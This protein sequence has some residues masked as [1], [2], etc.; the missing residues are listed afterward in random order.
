MP[1]GP[2]VLSTNSGGGGGDLA[3]DHIETLIM[4]ALHGTIGRGAL[5]WVGL[6]GGEVGWDLELEADGFGWI[7]GEEVYCVGCWRGG[8]GGA[9]QGGVGGST[10]GGVEGCF[11][12]VGD[13]AVGVVGSEVRLV[14]LDRG[15]ARCAIFGDD[16]VVHVGDR[17]LRVVRGFIGGWG[18]MCLG[19]YFLLDLYLYL[20]DVEGIKMIAQSGAVEDGLY[21]FCFSTVGVLGGTLQT[22]V[23]KKYNF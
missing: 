21:M 5:D 12:G 3:G 8:G 9:D 17:R 13:D 10:R 18:L 2:P 4:K 14:R 19:S 15:A 16:R 1:K 11:V 7:G 6:V 23:I 22:V 20:V